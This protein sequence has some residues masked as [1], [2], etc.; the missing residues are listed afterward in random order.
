MAVGEA[1]LRP[2]AGHPASSPAP[3]VEGSVPWTK[4]AYGRTGGATARGAALHS[5][6]QTSSRQERGWRTGESH[7]RRGGDES[8]TSLVRWR[9]RRRWHAWPRPWAARGKCPAEQQRGAAAA[10]IAACNPTVQPCTHSAGGKELKLS[11]G[12]GGGAPPRLPHQ[13]ARARCPPCPARCARGSKR[14]QIPQTKSRRSA[15]IWLCLRPGS[16]RSAG[17]RPSKACGWVWPSGILRTLERA[18]GSEG[19]P[20]PPL[21]IHH[22][23]SASAR[24]EV[25]AP[26]TVELR[27]TSF[28]PPQKPGRLPTRLPPAPSAPQLAPLDLWELDV[29]PR[30]PRV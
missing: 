20:P 7:A 14:R 23:S 12:G 1:L 26:S 25:L 27:S 24:P 4:Q 17:R 13:A 30:F 5:H 22:D 2:S 8:A 9:R 29:D 18:P 21:W 16:L 6:A 15:T 19:A 11:A 10:D 3:P 28:L